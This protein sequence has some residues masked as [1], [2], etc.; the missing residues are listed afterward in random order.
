M[1]KADIDRLING[2]LRDPHSLLGRHP[3][4]KGT[5]LRV[6]RP[7]AE[8]VNVLVDGEVVAKLEPVHPAGLFEGIVDQPI[9]DYQLEVS[10]ASG[11]TFMQRDPY[12]FIPSLG[13]IDLHLVGEGTHL[14]LWEKLGAHCTSI[15]GV[16]GVSF[17]VWA[18]NARGV[19]VVGEFNSWDGRLHPMRLLGSSGVWELFIPDLDEGVLYKYEV[20]TAQGNL[21]LK[22]DPYAFW[23]QTSP[24]T[25]S[26]VY[27]SHYKFTDDKWIAKREK[28]NAHREPMSTYEL[29]L[30]SWRRHGDD[31]IMSYRDIAPMLAKYC[32]DMGFTHVELMPV[33][34]H[35]FT[36]SWGYQV[37]NYFAPTARYGTPDDFKFFVDSLHNAG[38]GVL[39]DWVPAHFP[40]DEW[41]LAKF[42]GTALY[43]HVDPKKGEHPDWG[44]LVFN[45]GRNEV[46]NFLI[47]NALYWIEEFHIDGLRVDAVASMLYLDYSRKEG[48]WVPNKFGGREN[49]EAIEFL[50]ELNTIV[51][52]E[53]PGTLM[54]A[55]ESTAWPGVSRPVYL[56]GL[57][58]GFKWNMGWMH[59]TL[60][61]FSKEPIHRRFHHNQLTFSMMYAFSENFVLP[62]SHD[63][64]VHGKGSLINKMP[65]DEWQK[66]ANLRSLYAYMWAHPGKKLLFMGG[67]FAQAREWNHDES[68]DWHLLEERSHEGVSRMLADANRVYLETPALWELDH[69]PEGFR[70]IDAND[71]DNNV[72]SFYRTN[73]TK[74]QYLVCIANLSPVPR[75]GF[76]VGLPKGATYAEVLNTDAGGYAG[77]DV[78]NGGS[79]IAEK[80]SWHGLDYSAE[81]TLPPLGVIW[82]RA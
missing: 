53:F 74:S 46:R 59:D 55:E 36:G 44:T 80:V 50:K 5:I 7:E 54:V 22:S 23:M 25:A 13:E 57:G 40:K 41:A 73:S 20:V 16:D 43:E 17:A 51:Y 21:I 49:L 64:V 79:V 32:N 60:L 3:T 48:E 66:L 4:K 26:I 58:F 56:G 37:S 14:R 18:P 61:Y 67:E 33:A 27:K 8:A 77:S 24:Q 62:L 34:E 12:A 35:P 52:G 69:D 65:G 39:V 15:D 71:A 6:W 42:D 9:E 31:T 19:R 78:G 2:E 70:W 28:S 63:E 29:H 68:L 11:Q 10:Y 76:R 82:L 1:K 75:T 81:L 47:S 30:G 38:I 72:M 45:Y